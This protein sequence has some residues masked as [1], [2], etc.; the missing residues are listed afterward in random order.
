MRPMFRTTD[1][2][3]VVPRG[4]YRYWVR[5][6]D[7]NGVQGDWSPGREF[8]TS[9]RPYD[10]Q[11][12]EFTV[13]DNA[14][15]F[16]AETRETGRELWKT[17]GTSGGTIQVADIDMNTFRN[18]SHP[19]SM[20]EFNGSLYFSVGK[21]A[22]D[23]LYRTDGTE[24]GTVKVGQVAERTVPVGVANG[25]LF[26]VQYVNDEL[27]LVSFSAVIDASPE[28]L[29]TIPEH[30]G[31]SDHYWSNSLKSFAIVDSKL[32]FLSVEFES[33]KSAGLSPSDDRH[34]PSSVP[35]TFLTKVGTWYSTDGTA[36]G[37]RMVPG[38]TVILSE[39]NVIQSFTNTSLNSVQRLGDFHILD[40]FGTWQLTAEEIK[41]LSF[42]G[43]T[44]TGDA[45]FAPGSSDSVVSIDSS[46][47]AEELNVEFQNIQSV[48]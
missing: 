40:T 17:D 33:A 29:H 38:D 42:F 2:D 37:T 32:H 30:V 9:A 6:T 46:G 26:A 10:S 3:V 1:P 31:G 39:N 35:R 21:Y 11:P 22:V 25:H 13:F 48:D 28:V 5:P 16:A 4:R 15:F 36:A 34:L 18:G 23:P 45:V 19:G 12:T 7:A 14:V 27:R 47:Q 20:V 41:R 43:P 44:E 8:S 24:V